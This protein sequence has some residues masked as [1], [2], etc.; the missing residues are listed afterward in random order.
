MKRLIVYMLVLTGMCS[1][2]VMV[3]EA[4]MV[5]RPPAFDFSF[6]TADWINTRQF[7][8]DLQA[9]VTVTEVSPGMFHV[10]YQSTGQ[11]SDTAASYSLSAFNR[12]NFCLADYLAKK[13]RMAFWRLGFTRNTDQ[14]VSKDHS[15]ELYIYVQATEGAPPAGVSSQP[16]VW[17]DKSAPAGQVDTMCRQ[18]LQPGY[19]IMPVQAND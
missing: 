17:Q 2:L 8:D 9:K 10:G 18:I 5:W 3:S 4:R 15:T 13:K 1:T 6:Q 7:T 11:L 19:P 12:F 14:P 16:L